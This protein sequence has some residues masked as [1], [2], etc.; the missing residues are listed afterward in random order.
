M[1]K[2]LTAYGLSDRER[3]D[4][5]ALTQSAR[6]GWWGEYRGLIPNGM[7][8]HA[9]VESVAGDVMAYAPQAIP[10]FLQTSRYAQA[11]A[12]ADPALRSDEERRLAVLLSARRASSL[13]DRQGGTFTVVLSEAALMQHV[14]GSEAMPGQLRQLSGDAGKLPGLLTIRV[15]PFTAGAHPG[16]S[17]GPLTVIRFKG[18]AGVGAI[19]QG[20]SDGGVAI[21]RQRELTAAVRWFEALRDTALS[22]AE[23]RQLIREVIRDWR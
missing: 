4:I 22:S 15:V 13:R 21:A 12:T 19:C 23:S 8:D 7:V 6:A 1:L 5:A 2:L 14:G 11:V 18:V 17:T 3:Q 10:G 20:W 16:T 9:V